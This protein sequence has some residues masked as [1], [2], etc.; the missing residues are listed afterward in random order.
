MAAALPDCRINEVALPLVQDDSRPGHPVPVALDECRF[1]WEEGGAEAIVLAVYRAAIIAME[2]RAERAP[3]EKVGQRIAHGAQSTRTATAR[4]R[5]RLP[6]RDR[7]GAALRRATTATRQHPRLPQ[8]RSAKYE[9]RPRRI[10][11]AT[12]RERHS[13]VPPPPHGSTPG[14][15]TT[16]CEV[17]SAPRLPNRDRQGAALRRATTATR[18]P[19]GRATLPPGPW[20]SRPRRYRVCHFPPEVP[21]AKRHAPARPPPAAR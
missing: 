19:L 17:R 5:P 8:R 9:V 15:R 18:Q 11:T 4:Q 20:S 13:G 16:K 21:R 3:G 14:C 7:Q 10:R 6:N 12:G 1:G 2:P